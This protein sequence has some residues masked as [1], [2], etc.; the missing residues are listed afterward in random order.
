ML[1]TKSNKKSN[2]TTHVC[3]F[4][5]R[6]VDGYDCQAQY[7][8]KRFNNVESGTTNG[9][10]LEENAAAVHDHGIKDTS[11]ERVCNLSTKLI[12]SII[13]EC[14]KDGMS[15]RATKA[16]LA[17]NNLLGVDADTVEGRQRIH[18]KFYWYVNITL[19]AKN[20]YI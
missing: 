15:S 11:E 3:Q 4:S 17:Q 5:W 2:V 6:K 18:Q 20:D 12:D 14:I 7:R 9:L 19:N 1:D 16:K 10:I 8:I 13:I